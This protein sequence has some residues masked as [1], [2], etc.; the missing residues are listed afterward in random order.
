[1]R[2]RESGSDTPYWNT[3]TDRVITS[4]GGHY[5]QWTVGLML[6]NVAA[7]ILREYYSQVETLAISRGVP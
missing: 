2:S 5:S 1:M 4:S 3:T 6:I 7:G